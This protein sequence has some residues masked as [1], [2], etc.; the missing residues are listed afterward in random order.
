MQGTESFRLGESRGSIEVATREEAAAVALALAGQARRTLDIV[1]RHL[2][3]W[4]YDQ[5]AFVEAAKQLAL[6]S[7]RALIRVLIQDVDPILRDGHR[8]VALAQRLPTFLQI[9]VPAPQFR[10]FN[11]AFLVADG[12]G[13][14]HRELADRFEG[15]ASFHD[16]A[17]A[18]DLL[19]QFQPIWDAAEP[20]PNLRALRV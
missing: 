14:L 17:A 15:K 11:Q 16:P 12:V 1:S 9:R 10:D 6:G 8:L 3:P 20:D 7:R 18:R 5:A 19:R 2:D 4:L 13:Y